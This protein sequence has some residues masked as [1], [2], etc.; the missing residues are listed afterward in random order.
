MSPFEEA[1]SCR[2]LSYDR[3]LEGRRSIPGQVYLITT[4]T[5]RRAPVFA[6]FFAGAVVAREL[7]TLEREGAWSLVA[8]VVMPD[9]IHVLADLRSASLP[10]AMHTLKGRTSRALA[11]AREQPGPLWQKGY[12]E[13]ALRRDED[14]ATVARYVCANPVRANLVRSVRDYPLWD[15]C[16]V[17]GKAS[18]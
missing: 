13:H 5:R 12:H 11:V 17:G 6:D 14:V 2:P 4:A 16:W 10:V 3:M 9:H 15:C 8:W 18:G 7:V 1:A